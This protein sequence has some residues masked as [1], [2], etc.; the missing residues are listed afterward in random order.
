MSSPIT[1]ITLKAS[2]A[3]AVETTGAFTCCISSSSPDREQDVVQPAAV[4]AALAEWSAL[5]KRLPLSWSHSLGEGDVVG[6][7]DPSTAHEVAGQV[8]ISGVID[9]TVPK[10]AESWRLIVGG[11][12]GF[13]VGFLPLEATPRAGGGRTITRLDLLECAITVTP[14]NSDTRVMSH[15]ALVIVGDLDADLAAVEAHAAAH[16]HGRSVRRTTTNYSANAA[17]WAQDLFR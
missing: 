16:G 6:T 13:S 9:R 12:C 10:G 7:L 8:V 17:R 14:M 1:R 15:K 5:C 2:V 4:L 3:E 11:S